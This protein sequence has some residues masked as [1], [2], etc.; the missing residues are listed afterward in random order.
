MTAKY[1]P[2]TAK[3]H[4]KT[5]KYHPKTAKYHPKI[6]GY[7]PSYDKIFHPVQNVQKNSKVSRV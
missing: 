1:H 4:P 6:A 3:Y 5:A 2:K 7:H